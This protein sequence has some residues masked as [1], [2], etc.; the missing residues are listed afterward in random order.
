MVS[1]FFVLNALFIHVLFTCKKIV[2]IF[3]LHHLY[4]SVGANCFEDF[5][6]VDFSEVAFETGIVKD[7]NNSFSKVIDNLL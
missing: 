5:D 4:C 1:D 6:N 3:I 7:S 2:Q